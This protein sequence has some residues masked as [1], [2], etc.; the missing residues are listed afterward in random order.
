MRRAVRR[1]V[2]LVLGTKE[3]PEIDED[4]VFTSLLGE[5]CKEGAEAREVLEDRGVH[6]IGATV[7]F[8]G[9]CKNGF[10]Y[11]GLFGKIKRVI[12][13]TPGK[14]EYD[15]IVIRNATKKRV[16]VRHTNIKLVQDNS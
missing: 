6:P 7:Q 14:H 5:N 8:H 13:K 10:E 1:A 3:T 4:T 11:N 9:L 12:R 16:R 2:R 15:V